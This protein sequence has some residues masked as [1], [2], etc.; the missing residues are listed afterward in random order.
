MW[1]RRQ[2]PTNLTKLRLVA[3]KGTLSETVQVESNS[4]RN[5]AVQ[6]E[7]SQAET[8]QA[9]TSKTVQAEISQAESDE[10]ACKVWGSRGKSGNMRPLA[11]SRSE[12]QGLSLQA[13]M[14]E[15]WSV[16]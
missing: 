15:L 3:P 11:D 8:S 6:A 2:M 13:A 4:E 10:R 7:T 9:E 1:L 12:Q 5:K 16:P 14:C